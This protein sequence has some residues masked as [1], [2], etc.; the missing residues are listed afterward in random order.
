MRSSPKRVDNQGFA[1][2][3][4][5][6]N[7]NVLAS[8]GL[9]FWYESGPCEI[10]YSLVVRVGECNDCGS[11]DIVTNHRY[12]ADFAFRSE[13]GKLILVECKGSPWAWTGKT[14]SKHQAIKKQYPEMDLR[15]IF[16]DKNSK[17]SK[18]SKTS[19][20]EWCKRQKFLCESRLIPQRWLKE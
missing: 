4:E 12:T 6:R 13:S 11:K 5:L 17:I 10:S 20:A 18:T 15:F 7:Q 19:N 8:S 3:L 1:S 14:R 9:E 16:S 2:G